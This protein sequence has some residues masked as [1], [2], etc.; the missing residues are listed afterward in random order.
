MVDDVTKA[1]QKDEH[2]IVRKT[3]M[4]EMENLSASFLVS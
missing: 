3:R 4:Y 2:I 1:R